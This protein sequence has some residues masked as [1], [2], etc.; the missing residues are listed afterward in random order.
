MG[1]IDNY[2]LSSE[3]DTWTFEDPTQG[4]LNFVLV[5]RPSSTSLT[6]VLGGDDPSEPPC[7]SVYLADGSNYGVYELHLVSHPEPTARL[8]VSDDHLARLGLTRDAAMGYCDAASS[9]RRVLVEEIE[10]ACTWT[11]DHDPHSAPST[12][13]TLSALDVA[14]GKQPTAQ[15]ADDRRRQK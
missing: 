5:C 9:L 4:W 14:A 11:S 8:D 7:L 13:D 12:S 1:P 2:P 15:R 6:L 10:R 3:F